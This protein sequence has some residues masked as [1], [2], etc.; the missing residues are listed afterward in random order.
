MMSTRS[1]DY[2]SIRGG[3]DGVGGRSGS[4]SRLARGPLPWGEEE[5]DD[6]STPD[7]FDVDDGNGGQV[8]VN[9]ECKGNGNSDGPI[10]NNNNNAYNIGNNN[11]NNNGG[12][13]RTE[14]QIWVEERE[15]MEGEEEMG[16]EAECVM[17]LSR[18]SKLGM[19]KI[20]LFEYFNTR[21]EERAQCP[22]KRCTC[23]AILGDKSARSSV[24]KYLTWFKQRNK[25][26]QDSIVFKWFR[27]SSFLKPST[28]QKRTKNKMLCCLP[29]IDDSTAII[30]EMVRIHLICTCGLQ[31]SLA[32]G[33]KRYTS[34]RNA[35]KFTAVMP[36]HNSIGKKNYNAIKKNEWKYEPL[37]RHVEYLKNL[38]EVQATKV[39]ATL[40]DGM[41]GHANCDDSLDVTSSEVQSKMIFMGHQI[42]SCH[43][44]VVVIFH[45][46]EGVVHANVGQNVTPHN[47]SLG[48]FLYYFLHTMSLWHHKSIHNNTNNHQ[49][50]PPWWWRR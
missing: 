17:F 5:E 19:D 16:E 23:L 34:I 2:A 18:K 47:P 10:D 35:S 11:N 25:Y 50:P 4:S 37:L 32:F 7:A 8:E 3:G 12:G 30:D 13:V 36:A 44:P 46:V 24:A 41:Q 22:N 27:Y 6:D 49:T 26:E 29:Y 21:L 28:K 20:A 1:S 38:V 40:V 15:E 39:V 48:L 43:V 14:V 31:C 9:S 33:D 45:L 42:L